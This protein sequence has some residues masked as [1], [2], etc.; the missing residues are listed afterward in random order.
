MATAAEL[1]EGLLESM[2]NPVEDDN[3]N[4]TGIIYGD[5]GGGKTITA[6]KLGLAV[7]EVRNEP[8]SAILMV[9]A[10]NAWRSLKNHPEL[11]A[12][13]DAGKITRM[14]YK[15][16]SQLDTLIL[17]LEAQH[18]KFKN[19]KVIILDE[20]SSMTDQDGDVVL[21]AGAAAD[22]NKDPD[23]LTQ[24]D[25]GKT[26]ERMRRTITSLLKVNDIS[27]IFVAHQRQDEDKNVGYK[28]T[29]PRFMPKFSGTIREGLDFVVHMTAAEGARDGD[30]IAYVRQLQTS[31]TRTVVAKSRVGG[32]ALYETPE[33]FVAGVAKWLTG[34]VGDSIV[35]TVVDD[36]LPDVSNA[37]FSDAVID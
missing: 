35:D 27:V 11:M 3:Q 2:G 17:A 7:L 15:G 16:K 18:P 14:K 20:A 4:V 22:S 5:S 21:K 12:L 34:E 8:D 13:A 30:K 32:L 36:T 31:P 37:D 10:V 33:R 1:L 24:P 28:V 25:M 26:T 23:I 29:R 6:L 19:Y 9:D